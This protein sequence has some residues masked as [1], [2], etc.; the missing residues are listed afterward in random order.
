MLKVDEFFLKKKQI[1]NFGVVILNC[2]C[3][4]DVETYGILNGIYY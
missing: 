3:Y 2:G 4:D 1:Q